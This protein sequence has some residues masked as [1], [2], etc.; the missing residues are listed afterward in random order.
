VVVFIH[1]LLLVLLQDE[2]EA[3]RGVIAN[4]GGVDVVMK[5]A[6]KMKQ[7]VGNLKIGEQIT[8]NKV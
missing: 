3:V 1:R 6:A 8:F 5:D 4:L 7:V 2:A